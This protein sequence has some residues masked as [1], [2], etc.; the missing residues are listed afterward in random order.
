MFDSI[1]L[2]RSENGNP[3][4]A[5]NLAEALLYYQKVHLIIDRGT[6]CSLVK[7]IGID[8]LLTLL[9]RPGF[10]AVHC[11]E[12]LATHTHKIG[13]LEAYSYIA[14]TVTGDKTVGTL[15]KR[16]ERVQFELEQIGI[17]RSQARRKANIF[18]ERVPSRKLSGDNFIKGGIPAAAKQDL[19]NSEFVLAALKCTIACIPGGYQTGND[20]KFDVID[21]GTGLHVFTNIDLDRINRRQSTSSTLEPITVAH[22]LS[23]ILDYRADLALASFYGGDF[24]TSEATSSI[25]RS[26]HA[27]LVRRSSLNKESQQK[28]SEVIFPDSPCLSEIIDSG[29]RSFDEFLLLLD[30]A[31]KFKTWL[32]TVSPDESLVST[33]FKEVTSEGW[34]QRLPAKTIRYLFTLALDAT[35]PVAG[36]AFGMIDTFLLEKMLGG[37]RPNHFITT[38]LAPFIGEQ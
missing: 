16:V 24:Y 20:L 37:W 22:L 14:F 19:L 32:N 28:F 11:E 26:R 31:E 18:T 7:Q 34:F 23:K 2:R 30:K 12:M 1:V 9:K 3:I 38:R 17:P 29:E 8:T 4:S 27:E 13:V 25:L 36:L 35:N 33:Y 10:S 6:L 15:K 5:G 21:S